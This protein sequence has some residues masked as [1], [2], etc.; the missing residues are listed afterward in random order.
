DEMGPG[1]DG[2]P[3]YVLGSMGPGTKLPT[4]GHAPYTAL[5]DAYVES[6]LGMLDGGADAI[7]IETCQDLLQV[8]AA[9]TGSRRA[10]E[11]A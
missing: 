3:R 2:T 11:L 5:R 6:A 8:K 1:P 10:M 4:L 9:V 7:L